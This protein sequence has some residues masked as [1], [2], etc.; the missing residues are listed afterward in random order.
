[1]LD[2]PGEK[3]QTCSGELMSERTRATGKYIC[4]KH[5]LYMELLYIT[6]GTNYFNFAKY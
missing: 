1:M 6:K 2:I 4:L 5:F 3:N